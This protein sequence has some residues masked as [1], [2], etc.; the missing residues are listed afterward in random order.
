MKL[1][2]MIKCFLPTKEDE[3]CF[4]DPDKTEYPVVIFQ[5]NKETL[6]CTYEFLFRFYR[7]EL[8]FY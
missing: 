8:E 2:D 4:R 6:R 5:Y 7:F 3:D 1:F